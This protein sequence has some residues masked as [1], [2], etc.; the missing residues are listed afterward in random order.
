[1]RRQGAL[2]ALFIHTQV[3]A[4]LL[5]D[6]LSRIP[7]VVSLDATPRQYDELGAFYDH[8]RGSRIGESLKAA[9]HRHCFRRAARLV[10]WSEWSKAGL[11]DEYDVP[12]EKIKVIPPGVDVELWAPDHLDSHGD[13]AEPVRVLFVGGDLERK[14]GLVLLDAIGRLR[15]DGVDIEADIVTRDQVAPRPGVQI[16]HG[17]TANSP[18]LIALYRRADV[19]CLPTSAIACRWCCPRPALAGYRWC[20]PTSGRSTRSSATV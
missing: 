17:L 2:D 8:R 19:F 9:V 16:H 13:G 11:V 15:D 6:V 1:M 7:T 14:G 4:T 5:P 20:P 12:P 3:P 10:T 18:D